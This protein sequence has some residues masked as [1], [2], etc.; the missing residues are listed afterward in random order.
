MHKGIKR[1][2]KVFAVDA[3]MI[4]LAAQLTTVLNEGKSAGNVTAYHVVSKV[5]AATVENEI[6]TTTLV[7]NRNWSSEDVEILTK[8]AMAEAEGE[9]TEGK[10]FVM[11]VV[12][13]RTCAEGFP[14]TVSDVVF[15]EGQFETVEYG[16]R[17]WNAV[18]DEECHEAYRMILNGWDESEGALYFNSVDCD[19]WASEN[20][21]YLYT[22][23]NHHFYR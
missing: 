17:Y 22:V 6:K 12:L 7:R 16:G 13:N 1:K 15:E 18:P 10:A 20:E 21:E 11:M 3:A 14:D 23:G 2:M 19:S 5:E 4:F 8:I 9:G